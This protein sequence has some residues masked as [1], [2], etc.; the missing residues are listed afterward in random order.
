M[1]LSGIGYLWY[2]DNR[3]KPVSEQQGNKRIYMN[4]GGKKV[5]D[6]VNSRV[7]DV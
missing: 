5:P 1:I 4:G 3:I 7:P 2:N 6:V